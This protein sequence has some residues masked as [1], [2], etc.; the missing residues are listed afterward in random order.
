MLV[1]VSYNISTLYLLFQSWTERKNE[2]KSRLSV[3]AEITAKHEQYDRGNNYEVIKNLKC[4]IDL[5]FFEKWSRRK[6]ATRG[7][8]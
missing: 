2:I 5:T 4:R 3:T 6:R 8:V 1:P 7:S